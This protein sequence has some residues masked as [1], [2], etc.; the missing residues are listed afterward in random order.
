MTG[1][2]IDSATLELTSG[3]RIP[4]VGLGV[5]EAPR[6]VARTAVEQAL[7]IGYRHIDTARIYGNES[8]VGAAVRASGLP[9]EEIFVTTKLWNEDQGYDKAFRA[10]DASLG[11]LGFD[12][13][14][15]Y[16]VHWPV[17][18][19]RLDSWR[20]LEEIHESGRARSIG[21]SNFMVPHL[22]ELLEVARVI[23]AVN[24]VE[25]HPFLQQREVRAACAARGIAVE[26][27]SP[28]TRG[29]R[30]GHPTFAAIAAE[31]GRTPAQIML[32]WALQ[33]DLIVLPKSVHEARIAENA[34][35]FDF[36]LDAGAMARIDALD[37]GTAFCWDPRSQD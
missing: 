36:E 20:A 28:L 9:R 4:R 34:R 16:L 26:A 17:R 11:R 1:K 19:K 37:E 10:F 24:Q 8:D 5:W 27:Y 7:R 32:R 22:N 15:L 25:T 29:E 31:V 18:G 13:V 23:P 2:T 6:G 3:A 33:H 21:V 14:D 35:L 30:I 12:Y